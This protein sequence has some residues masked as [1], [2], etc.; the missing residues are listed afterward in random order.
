MYLHRYLLPENFGCELLHWKNREYF[1]SLRNRPGE[2]TLSGFDRHRCIFIHIPK[3]GGVSVSKA[4]FG[5]RSG[6]HSSITRYKKIF[7][8]Q[9]FYNYYKFSFVRNPYTRLLSAFNYFKRGGYV[10]K[11][12]EISAKYFEP[13]E[14]LDD[15]V[16]T[17]LDKSNVWKITHLVP[18]THF[19]TNRKGEL[20]I[21]FLGRYENLS[22]DFKVVANHLRIRS[23]LGHHNRSRETDSW[24]DCYTPQSLEAVNEL[25]KKDFELLN[26]DRLSRP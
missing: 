9:T 5:A 21:D 25:Y 23:E 2:V 4:L 11:D 15:F 10:E 19:I 17:W 20:E 13:F 18:Q 26:Y 16:K 7:G 8:I 3:A 22:N 6:G 12:R 24:I 1:R 14:T